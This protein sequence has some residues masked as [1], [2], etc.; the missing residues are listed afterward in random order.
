MRVL[1]TTTGRFRWL[2]DPETTRYAILSHTWNPE[3]EQS[4]QD[5]AKLHAH[6]AHSKSVGHP[7]ENETLRCSSILSHPALSSKIKGACNVAKL[8]GYK[9]IWIDSCC[10][11][12]SS[13]AELSEAINSMFDWY[14]LAD[15]CYAYLSDVPDDVRELVVD[16]LGCRRFRESKWHTRG[17]TLQEL[18]AP[19]HVLFLTCNWAPFGTKASLAAALSEIT[20]ISSQILIHAVSLESFSVAQRMSWAARRATT[21]V[22]DRAYSLLGLFG[23]HMPTIYGEGRGAFLRLQEEIMKRIPDQTLF[24]WG[25]RYTYSEPQTQALVSLTPAER[26]WGLLADSPEEFVHYSH[27]VP[28]NRAEFNALLPAIWPA[29]DI[30]DPTMSSRGI[31]LY[32]P[33]IDVHHLP[34]NVRD[35]LYH[36]PIVVFR[37]A[38]LRCWDT[39]KKTLFMLPLSAHGGQGS[40]VLGVGNGGHAAF[41][42]G[43]NLCKARLFAYPPEAI[44]DAFRHLKMMT[45]SVLACSLLDRGRSLTIAPRITSVSLSAWCIPLLTMQGLSIQGQPGQALRAR[46]NK[47]AIGTFARPL[48]RFSF[49]LRLCDPP[50]SSRITIAVAPALADVPAFEARPAAREGQIGIFVIAPQSGSFSPFPGLPCPPHSRIRCVSRE[51][52]THSLNEMYYA[53]KLSWAECELKV[54]DPAGPAEV[55]AGAWILR[56]SLG[57]VQ[58]EGSG[59]DG[60]GGPGRIQPDV[61]AHRLAHAVGSLTVEVTHTVLARMPQL[62]PAIDE[63]SEDAVQ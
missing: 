29:V 48:D 36:P 2:D 39:E 40:E 27:V 4:Y 44:R 23:I 57:L 33:V 43:S 12:K 26:P 55:T 24:A 50:S 22:E 52:R 38:L 13:S 9:L 47:H 19:K 45:V 7:A 8:H 10:I 6:G 21:R 30:P 34:F 20:G 15:I 5:L 63:R 28:L 49:T 1:D 3:G 31:R 18:I 14:R 60:G 59:S 56:V 61:S 32:A 46:K 16:P 25:P 41:S 53:G 54:Q 62:L 35:N 42:H 37:A 17:W 51:S 11:D 58:G